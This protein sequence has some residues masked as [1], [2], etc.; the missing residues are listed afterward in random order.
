MACERSFTRVKVINDNSFN[1]GRGGGTAEGSSF[2]CVSFVEKK[3][4]SR[5]QV[6]VR[7]ALQFGVDST[8]D[9]GT[10]AG[11]SFREELVPA[12]R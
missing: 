9:P 3:K 2:D 12:R 7:L 5:V 4:H 11:G 8:M 1:D 10:R 6:G